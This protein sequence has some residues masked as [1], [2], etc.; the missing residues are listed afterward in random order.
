MCPGALS[1]AADALGAEPRCMMIYGRAEHIDVLGN[2]LAP[3]PTLHPNGELERFKEGCFICQP[4]VVFRHTL[5][6]L[7]GKLDDSFSCSFDFDYWVRAFK[8]FPGRIG[9]VDAA[10]AQSRLHEACITT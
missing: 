7:L 2:V 1:R 5:P 10:Q 4:T 3:C 6:L 9:F 8:V